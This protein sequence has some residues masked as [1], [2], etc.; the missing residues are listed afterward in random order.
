MPPPENSAQGM[1]TS[2]PDSA[3]GCVLEI[4]PEA[5][6][7]STARLFVGAVGRH[8]GVD[9]DSVEDLKLAVSEACNA[10]IRIRQLE[11][12]DRS[13]R[14]ESNSRGSLLMFDVEDAVEAQPSSI[15]TST[16]D[17]VRGL[18]LELIQTL[19][20]GAEMSPGPGGGTSIRLSVLVGGADS[21]A[22]DH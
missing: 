10:A 9:E 1:M 4:P 11:T 15:A 3:V 17:L 18:S 8:F 5:A 19:F 22:S 6:Y 20:P 13:I 12:E 16:E 14:I 7:V 21:E 2:E